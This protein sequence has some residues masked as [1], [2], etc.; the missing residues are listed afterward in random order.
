MR[1]TYK[2][3]SKMLFEGSYDQWA[4]KGGVSWLVV[5]KARGWCL[6][7]VVVRGWSNHSISM[8]GREGIC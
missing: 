4:R 2:G 8:R 7:E 5:I 6:D 1:D 3:E